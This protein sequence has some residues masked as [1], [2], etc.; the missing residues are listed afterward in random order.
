M[1]RRYAEIDALAKQ[2]GSRLQ[3]PFTDAVVHGPSRDPGPEVERPRVVFRQRLAVSA[4]L[5]RPRKVNFF[6]PFIRRP[7]ATTLISIGLVLA[8]MT[9]YFRLPVSPLPQVDIP[10]ITVTANVPGA[11]PEVM[12]SSVATPLERHLGAIA[13]VTDIF[14][15]SSVGFTSIAVIFD[16][17]RNIDGA[18]RDVQAAINGAR[19]DL[20]SAGLRSNPTYR[21][22]DPS[23][24]PVLSLALTSDTLTRGG[25]MMPPRPC[26]PRP[27][28]S[29]RAWAPWWWAEARC[30]R[31]ASS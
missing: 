23:A 19:A 4:P 27:S 26:S 1:A 8:G 3:A 16:L 30:R 24:Q 17:E 15:Q 18:A 31:S 12:A 5:W 25:S 22:I 11:S 6:E 7:V 29:C 10:V 13:N 21:K 14:S 9:A 2:L 20:A 28:P